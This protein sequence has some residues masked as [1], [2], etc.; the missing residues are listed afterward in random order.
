MLALILYMPVLHNGYMN[1]FGS[2]GEVDEIFIINSEWALQLQP[3]LK[4]DIRALQS[5]Q[6]VDILSNT[7][8]LNSKV[9]ELKEISQLANFDSF[10]LPD[11]EI[12]RCFA[13]YYLDLKTVKLLPIFLRWDRSSSTHD[14]DVYESFSVS[15][16]ETDIRLLA[17]CRAK[18]LESAD[19][20]RQVGGCVVK[21][22]NLILPPIN[23]T[24][25]PSPLQPYYDGDPRADFHKGQRIELGTAMHVELSLIV[26]AASIGLSL[27][28][29][30]LYVTT[31]PCPWCAKAIAYSGISRVYF[32][33][34]YSVLDAQSILESNDV[35]II[36][37]IK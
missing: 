31:F 3:A 16:D 23:N 26:S 20:W 34:G 36:R 25:V 10:I 19:W 4:K 6:M 12:S 32:D 17:S 24:H 29:S 15:R 37:I 28:G 13:E 30:Y 27:S 8:L 22:G 21:N 18:A 35:K 7:K 33:E 2:V 14:K 9:S 1:L 5:S 11:D